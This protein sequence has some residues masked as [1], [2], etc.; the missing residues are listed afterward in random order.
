MGSN[1]LAKKACACADLVVGLRGRVKGLE[2]VK[3]CNG[4]LVA[5]CGGAWRMLVPVVV[6]RILVLEKLSWIPSG[7]PSCWKV[8]RKG[9]TSDGE[10]QLVASSM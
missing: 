1:G 7:L 10:R 8:W 9:I 6:V 3:G 4:C 2:I 5:E